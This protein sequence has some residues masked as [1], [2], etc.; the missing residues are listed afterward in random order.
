[1]APVRRCYR[2]LSLRQNQLN[3]ED[4]IRKDLPIGSG[5]IESAHRY[6]VQKRLKLPGSWWTPKNAEH[7]LGLAGEQ[8]QWRMAK[9][10]GYQLPVCRLTTN[11]S[12]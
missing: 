6:L 1:L 12:V 8:T 7:M 5:E 3:Y 11:T 10:L 4:A 9:L 2:Y